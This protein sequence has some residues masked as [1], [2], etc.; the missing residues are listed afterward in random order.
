MKVEFKQRIDRNIRN[1]CGSNDGLFL[2]MST[3]SRKRIEVD[4]DA[5]GII[6]IISML[7]CCR[8]MCSQLRT[9]LVL[10][11]GYDDSLDSAPR[12]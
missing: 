9:P 4:V 7:E 2:C 12:P 10:R 6:G 1:R 5:L 11:A 3:I 8:V